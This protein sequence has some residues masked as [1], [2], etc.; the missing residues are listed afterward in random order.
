MLVG[1][2]SM[3]TQGPHAHERGNNTRIQQQQLKHPTLMGVVTLDCRG[4]KKTPR[5][6]ALV[7][8]VSTTLAW[9]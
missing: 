9:R 8:S 4:G 1:R 7:V 3:L 6:G 2:I 5:S